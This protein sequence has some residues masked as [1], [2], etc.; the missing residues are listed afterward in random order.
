MNCK[1]LGKRRSC[2]SRLSIHVEGT[3]LR[4]LSVFH[5]SLSSVTLL[6]HPCLH[7]TQPWGKAEVPRCWHLKGLRQQEFKNLSGKETGCE[8][9][10]I[11]EMSTEG[12]LFSRILYTRDV[13]VCFF[14]PRSDSVTKHDWENPIPCS[15]CYEWVTVLDIL[16]HADFC[17]GE[18]ERLCKS[19]AVKAIICAALELTVESKAW[20]RGRWPR[21]HRTPP[22]VPPKQSQHQ[23]SEDS[24]AASFFVCNQHLL[25]EMGRT[26]PN[27]GFC[28][29]LR[30]VI[31]Q[32]KSIFSWSIWKKKNCY[33]QNQQISVLLEVFWNFR[34]LCVFEE[35]GL[36]I[37]YIKKIFENDTKNEKW[38]CFGQNLSE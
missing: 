25:Q 38:Q 6:I 21:P 36:E 3:E 22:A 33:Q 34:C 32:Y 7:C 9:S 37:I 15:H 4:V 29:S 24:L 35:G 11:Q 28:V 10:I 23:S 13:F 30:T 5:P 17:C 31:Q 20:R 27:I 1:A 16:Q 12:S 8:S 2:R 18:T 14:L 26:M 19:A